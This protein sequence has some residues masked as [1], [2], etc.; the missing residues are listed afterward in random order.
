MLMLAEPKRCVL[1]FI[2][3]VDRI[4]VLSFII[5]AYVW[6]MLGK[7]DVF[8]QPPSPPHTHTH[9]L[10]RTHTPVSSPEKAVNYCCKT[11]HLR[12]LRGSWPLLILKEKR[13]LM[14]E[15]WSAFKTY[16]K[17]LCNQLPRVF[18]K[19]LLLEL[20]LQFSEIKWCTPRILMIYKTWKVATNKNKT[21]LGLRIFKAFNSQII[22]KFRPYSPLIFL[23]YT[24]SLSFLLSKN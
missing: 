8:V 23:E 21:S 9:K 5:V 4:T 13:A 7:G 14:I 16:A 2:Y 17:V 1:W 11:L 24:L 18:D 15:S 10:T 19:L 12:C 22:F 6:Q 20:Q 3:F